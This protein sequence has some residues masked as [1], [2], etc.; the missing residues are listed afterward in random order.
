MMQNDATQALSQ[1]TVVFTDLDGS[2]LD[3][4]DYSHTAAVPALTRLRETGIPVVAATS[5]T[6]AEVIALYQR[7]DHEHPFIF[8]NG[9]GI[10]IPDGYFPHY[11]GGRREGRYHL[12]LNGRPYP[13]IVAC[14]R[15]LRERFGWRFTGFADWDV[16]Q[17]I[18]RT[19]LSRDAA[20]AAKKRLVSEPLLWEDDPA[21]LTEFARHLRE[22]N[23]HLEQGGRFL[24]VQGVADKG[25][26]MQQLAKLYA[27][28]R[29][30]R[31]TTIACGDSPNDRGMLMAA[32]L[33]VVIP[34]PGGRHLAIPRT[35]GVYCA[36][37]QGPAGWSEGIEHFLF[38][39]GI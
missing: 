10:G 12:H 9:G 15:D 20:Q 39:P 1:C 19:G 32:D 21:A 4:A 2:L 28:H 22:Q 7:L 11:K 23:L 5:K 29:G 3:P 27:D 26:A 35:D 14:L 31:V 36:S 30:G 25:Q 8:E 24:S 6:A 33:A 18:A 34:D 38:R 17:V 13:G 37:V 16:E